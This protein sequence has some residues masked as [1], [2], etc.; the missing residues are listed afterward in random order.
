MNKERETPPLDDVLDHY[1]ITSA[2]TGSD[3][4]AET[5][6]SYPQYAHDLRELAAFRKIQEAIPNHAYTSEEEEV[7]HARGMSV[8]QNLLYQKRHKPASGEEHQT[9]A[10]LN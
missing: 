4:L 9:F 1:L 3:T 8:V 5:I 7:L 6:D 2:E 10:S